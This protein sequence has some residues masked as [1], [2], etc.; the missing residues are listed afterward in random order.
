MTFDQTAI[1]KVFLTLQRSELPPHYQFLTKLL[2]P[3]RE[4][5][6]FCLRAPTSKAKFQPTGLTTKEFWG[7]LWDSFPHLDTGVQTNIGT[8][9]R[10]HPVCGSPPL[11]ST[12]KCL[13]ECSH[14]QT[15]QTHQ[16]T[17]TTPH[18]EKCLFGCKSLHS[19]HKTAEPRSQRSRLLTAVLCP[20]SCLCSPRRR[21]SFSS[22]QSNK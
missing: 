9:R 19:R 16:Q 11:P 4:D 22:K 18:T 1:L 13:G 20:A 17:Q 12:T 5:R 21:C 3:A 15:V 10:P 8:H 6:K 14:F 7:F 2:D